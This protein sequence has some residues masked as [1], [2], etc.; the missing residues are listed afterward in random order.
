MFLLLY[1]IFFDLLE[2]FEVKIDW[3]R[4]ADSDEEEEKG[5]FDTEDLE[6]AEDRPI[7]PMSKSLSC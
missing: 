4:W 3:N 5:G 2:R 6:G 7:A 1:Y